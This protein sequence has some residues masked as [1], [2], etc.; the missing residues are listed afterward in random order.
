MLCFAELGSTKT[1]TGG[2]YT[3]IE[4]AFG[5]FAG[6]LANT[7]FWVGYGTLSGAAVLNVMSDMLGIWF[8]IFN[9]YWFRVIFLFVVLAVFAIVNI[10]GV[11]SGNRMAIILTILKLTPLV[12]L[13]VIGVFSVRSEN[14]AII[15]LP[16]IS[17]LGAAC[18][19]LFFAFQG[20]ESAL[21]ISG[22]IKNPG[23]NIPKGIFMGIAGILFIYLSIQFV[24]TGVLG[25]DL[26]LFQEAPLAEL[27]N[28]LI[29]PIG[30]TILIATGVIS[31][32]GVM[33]SDIMVTP[34]LPFAASE[35][36]LLPR[37]LSRIH[38]KYRS[39]SNAIILYSGAI[40]IMAISGGF[41]TLAVLASS[42]TLIIYLGVVLA[43]FKSRLKPDLANP[44]MFI[45]PGGLLVPILSLIVL[46]WVLSYV[47][48]NEFI[49]IGIFLIATAIFYLGYA[50]WKKSNKADNEPELKKGVS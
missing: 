4:D 6:F 14:L 47:P 45:V 5:P 30:G 34:R 11:K 19:L 28:R 18:L 35:D 50:W 31:M 42:A 32:Y 17:S 23:K 15:E 36:G 46:V 12:L 39:P 27:A 22:E 8:P 20:T 40:F 41:K 13:V 33:G 3:M 29:G 48:L 49:A 9:A 37:A 24:A 44:P 26:A 21:S 16:E 1:S 7:L 25:T 2:A 10:R 38:P 43:M